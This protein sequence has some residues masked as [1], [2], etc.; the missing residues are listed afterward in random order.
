MYI[1]ITIYIFYNTNKKCFTTFDFFKIFLNAILKIDN[2]LSLSTPILVTRFYFKT[3]S[4][5]EKR[6]KW[7]NVIYWINDIKY[8]GF[9]RMVNAIL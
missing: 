7:R 3:C 5:L 6:S 9:L 4:I 2:L 8:V 1:S